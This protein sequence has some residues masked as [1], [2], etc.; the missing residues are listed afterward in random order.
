MLWDMNLYE[1]APGQYTYTL[2][3]DAE[4]VAGFIAK[5][6]TGDGEVSIKVIPNHVVWANWRLIPGRALQSRIFGYP[7]WEDVLEPVRPVPTRYRVN[8]T[9]PQ[10]GFRHGQ[11]K[12]SPV[13]VAVMLIIYLSGWILWGFGWLA[14]VKHTPAAW[15]LAI[16]LARRLG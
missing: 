5:E 14:F 16:Y 1:P 15:R 13:V 10:A 2:L 9:I 7:A 12:A 4:F 8:F 3:A 11:P 6:I